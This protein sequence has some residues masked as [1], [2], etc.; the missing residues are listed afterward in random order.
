MSNHAKDNLQRLLAA[1][2][3]S[4]RRLSE[5]SGLDKR[6]IRGILKGDKKPQA[7]TLNRLAAG[8]GVSVD[9]L[10]VDPALLIYRRFDRLTNPMVE[11][12]MAAHAELFDGWTQADF[13]ELQSRVGMGGP[14]TME[15]ALG[16]VR[17][18]NRKRELH[19]KL[20]VLLESTHADLSADILNA[21][22]DKVVL[23]TKAADGRTP[24]P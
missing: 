17:L 20:D 12:A 13:D 23:P 7:R 11:E 5:L 3:V 21:L 10:F 4:I 19:G 2:G 8:L 9:E 6:T 15:G 24:G 1:A 22:Y 16:A 18:M 14:L